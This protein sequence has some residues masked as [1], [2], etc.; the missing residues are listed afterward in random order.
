MGVAES[1]TGGWATNT[2]MVVKLIPRF[3]LPWL[4]GSCS[5]PEISAHT[6][7]VPWEHQLQVSTLGLLVG[8]QRLKSNQLQNLP[9]FGNWCTHGATGSSDSIWGDRRTDG[10]TC[11]TEWVG[12]YMLWENHSGLGE[13]CSGSPGGL[14]RHRLLHEYIEDL[15]PSLEGSKVAAAPKTCSGRRPWTSRTGESTEIQPN[16]CNFPVRSHITKCAVF[17]D[18][19]R[20]K[21]RN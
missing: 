13:A 16:V 11:W 10:R 17:R 7:C 19:A 5:N 20:N 1:Q 15:M 8:Y 14:V 9:G 12:V 21:A 4:L 2:F 18:Q 3:C 6:L